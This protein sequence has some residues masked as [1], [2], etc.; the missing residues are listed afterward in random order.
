MFT[1]R[2][3]SNLISYLQISVLPHSIHPAD[4]LSS[5][6]ATFY[7]ALGNH[8]TFRKKKH[9]HKPTQI[10][11]IVSNRSRKR[12]HPHIDPAPMGCW[13]EG[14][15]LLV[16]KNSEMKWGHGS[17]SYECYSCLYARRDNGDD[18][19]VK[20]FSAVRRPVGMSL[21]METRGL[22]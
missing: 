12:T 10:L 5:V 3:L 16:R 1:V 18:L 11:I 20:I 2:S 21:S 19:K 15:Q 4:V 22:Q 17:F 13:W 8:F 9:K 6:A 7:I 14:R